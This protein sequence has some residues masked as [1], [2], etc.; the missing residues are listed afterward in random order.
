M[1]AKKRAEKTKL[2]VATTLP[3]IKSLEIDPAKEVTTTY[4]L[5][6][7][8]LEEANVD[9]TS[10]LTN[11]RSV[12]V[13]KETQTEIPSAKNNIQTEREKLPK[14]ATRFDGLEHWLDFDD[15]NQV[16]KGYR[17]KHCHAQA[18][19]FCVKC[20]VHLCF[21]REKKKGSEQRKVRNCF[22]DFH[23]ISES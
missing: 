10:T 23:Q 15:P 9:K 3:C 19:T 14:N 5:N 6:E 11:Y 17:C 7:P 4:N 22:R 1:S 12:L 20:N 8:N 21:V 2:P 18:N 16:R 13:S